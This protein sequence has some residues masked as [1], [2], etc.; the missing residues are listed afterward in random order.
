[1]NSCC[2]CNNTISR[3]LMKRIRQRVSLLN[4]CQIDVFDL[5]IIDTEVVVEPC[6]PMLVKRNSFTLRE[7][8]YLGATNGR[9]AHNSIIF[10]EYVDSYRW[11]RRWGGYSPDNTTSVQENLHSSPWSMF[12]SFNRNDGS[13]RSVWMATLPLPHPS[14]VLLVWVVLFLEGSIIAKGTFRRQ[15]STFPPCSTIERYFPMWFL[16]SAIFVDFIYT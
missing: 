7:T 14:C 12:Q 3:V 9:D 5:P 4:Y 6:F 16:N 15:I 11:Q 13:V 1:M 10:L 8:S 2:G